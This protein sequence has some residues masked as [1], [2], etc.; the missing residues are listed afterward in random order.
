MGENIAHHANAEIADAAFL[1]SPAHRAVMMGS[2]WEKVGIG[3]VEDE[4]G[5]VYVTELFVR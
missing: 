3:V 2:Q 4:Q 1:S 5:F